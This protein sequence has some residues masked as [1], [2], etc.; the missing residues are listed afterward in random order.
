MTASE[1]LSQTF[2]SCA[3]AACNNQE[4]FLGEFVRCIQCKRTPYCS[5]T[6]Q[7]EDYWT[8]HVFCFIDHLGSVNQTEEL[9]SALTKVC[10]Q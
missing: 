5:T 3:L 7:E 9:T 8:E 4:A 2:R 6:C 10:M 1:G